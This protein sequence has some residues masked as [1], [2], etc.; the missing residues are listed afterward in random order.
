M[1]FFS[2]CT[3]TLLPLELRER[4]S[5]VPLPR[6]RQSEPRPRATAALF[7]AAALG[8]CADQPEPACISTV[9]P[10]AVRLIEQARSE[11][12]LG[13]CD[14]FGPATFNVDPEVGLSPYY[15]RDDKG[16]PDYTH[17]SL[18]LQTAEL[19]TLVYTAQ[20][21]GIENAAPDAQLYSRGDFSSS[22][23]DDQHFCTVPALSPTH[24][25]LP[26][27]P[28]VPDDPATADADESF[29]GQAAADV[30]LTW[31]NVRVYVTAALFGTQ[32]D[33]D[34]LDTRVSDTGETCAITYK[35]L[36][37]APAVSCAALD[38]DDVPLTN[39]DGTP[40][41]DPTACD[42]EADP[43]KGRALGS[44]ISPSSRFT[45]DPVTAYCMLEGDSVPALR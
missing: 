45:C 8:A 28:A 32:M 3:R 43:A 24:V 39:P 26:S 41:L 35:A 40:Q 15:L 4:G 13:V 22:T 9:A 36:G 2:R 44:G 10:F 11:S 42:P 6:S 27:I 29:P 1:L 23:P 7:I 18:A 31:S 19:G 14:A 17:G 25:V 38:A 5:S 21:F 16:Q 20:G 34:L 33:A 30:T 12:S 37:L